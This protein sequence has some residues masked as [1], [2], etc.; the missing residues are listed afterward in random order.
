LI[1][2]VQVYG[3]RT[4]LQLAERVPAQ[5]IIYPLEIRARHRA[6]AHAPAHDANDLLDL[7]PKGG[8]QATFHALVHNELRKLAWSAG[9]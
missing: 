1:G 4:A 8:H 2:D 9:N 7:H 5:G 6:G 3:V